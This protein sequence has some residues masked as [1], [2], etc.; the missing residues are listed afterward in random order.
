MRVGDWISF[1]GQDAPPTRHAIDFGALMSDV[2]LLLRGR[3]S[4]R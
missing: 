3:E 2:L 4:C 1:I